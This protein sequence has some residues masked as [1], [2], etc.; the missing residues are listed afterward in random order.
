MMMTGSGRG[1][2]VQNPRMEIPHPAA[3]VM[4]TFQTPSLSARKPDEPRP[5][6]EPIWRNVIE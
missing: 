1:Y 4:K 2:P 3:M 5:R 6:N